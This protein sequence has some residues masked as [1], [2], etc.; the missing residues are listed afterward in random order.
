MAML[1]HLVLSMS[2]SKLQTK[3]TLGLPDVDRLTIQ[4]WSRWKAQNRLGQFSQQCR[5][6]R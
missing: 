2:E 6:R 4:F 5:R 3:L 1:S